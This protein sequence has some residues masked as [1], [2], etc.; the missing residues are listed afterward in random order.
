MPGATLH[1][2]GHAHQHHPFHAEV[3]QRGLRLRQLAGA[4]VDQ[5]QVRQHAFFFHRAAE[6]AVDGLAHG[7][8]VIAGLDA[9][10]V[11][12]AVLAAH[13]TAGVEHHA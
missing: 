12:T 5:Q 13:R 8:V 6:P 1:A 2:L 4:A 7:G 9:A 10:D 11:E 3:G